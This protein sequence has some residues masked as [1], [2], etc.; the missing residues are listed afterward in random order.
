MPVEALR[1]SPFA[2][3][4][5]LAAHEQKLLAGMR[6]HVSVQ[7]AQVRELLPLVARHLVQQRA[8]HMHYFIVREGQ[9]KVLAPR[10]QQTKSQRVVIAAAKQRISLKVFERVVH[11][12]HVPFEIETE[13][14]RVN[15]MT[16]R[17][18]CG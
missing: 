17:W 9:D 13:P 10:V 3:L 4:A 5:K 16:Y 14:T 11:P 6:P 7:R 1:L 12:T 2:P 15:R 18:P 8:L